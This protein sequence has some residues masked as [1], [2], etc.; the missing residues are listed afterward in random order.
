MTGSRPWSR[1][2]RLALA[3]GLLLAA[4]STGPA[5]WAQTR[6]EPVPRPAASASDWNDLDPAR[7][8]A[9]SPLR[10]EWPR[11][12]ESQR[13]RWLD[14]ADQFPSLSPESRSRLQS[15]MAD[16]ARLTPAQRLDARERYRQAQQIDPAERRARWEQF[17]ALPPDERQRWSE[18]SGQRQRSATSPPA[19]PA[20][21]ARPGDFEAAAEA[22]PSR[23]GG[24]GATTP[25]FNT[26]LPLDAATPARGRI[27]TSPGRL[28]RSTL[29]PRTGPQASGRDAGPS[30]Q[31]DPTP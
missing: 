6:G 28:D 24:V 14:V 26:L 4:L 27:E 17:Q 22:A 23:R 18:R 11:L 21:P 7:R 8:S 9:L 30:G 2:P 31:A 13:L 15:R 25:R 29:L 1:S 3:C 20:D 12:D 16:W 5:T 19:A 10:V